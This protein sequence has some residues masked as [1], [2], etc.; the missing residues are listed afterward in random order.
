MTHSE[1]P[2]LLR[3]F[4]KNRNAR[5]EEAVVTQIIWSCLGDLYSLAT[6]KGDPMSFTAG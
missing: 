5:V 2:T 4:D 3:M 6:V 1:L